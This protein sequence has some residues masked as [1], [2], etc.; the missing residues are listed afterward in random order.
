MFTTRLL[1]LLVEVYYKGF[2]ENKEEEHSPSSR[3]GVEDMTVV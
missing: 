1:Y 2:R 3:D